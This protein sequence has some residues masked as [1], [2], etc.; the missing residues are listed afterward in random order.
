LETEQ[1]LEKADYVRLKN[2]SIG[3]TIPKKIISGNLRVSL[4]AQN[5]FTFTSYSGYDPEGTMDS[6]GSGGQVD[7]NMGIDGI[8]Y[9]VPRTF[10]VGL[11][12][13]Y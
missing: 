9:P 10:T 1:Y 11:S 12:F 2:I 8:S 13:T 4:S 3:Y 7:T 6:R 5:L